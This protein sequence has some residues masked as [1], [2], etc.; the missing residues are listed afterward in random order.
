MH[1]VWN[2]GDKMTV[3]LFTTHCPKCKV[4]EMKLKQK[5]IEFSQ[6]DDVAYMLNVL[7]IQA[8]PALKVDD[9]VYD[10][11]D[12]VKWINAQEAQK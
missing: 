3:T 12:A 7:K 9:T 1:C 10:F 4:L 8:A 11:G 2:G 6:N 5:N